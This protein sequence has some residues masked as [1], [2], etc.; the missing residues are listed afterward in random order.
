[1]YALE[2]A[3]SGSAGADEV[4][5]RAEAPAATLE[6]EPARGAARRPV[7]PAKPEAA[8]GEASG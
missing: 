3:Q 1:V 7:V 4:A 6:P 5:V 2:R 8:E